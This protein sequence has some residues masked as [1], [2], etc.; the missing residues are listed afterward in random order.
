MVV[1]NAIS[2]G[3]TRPH[4]RDPSLWTGLPVAR[5][6]VAAASGTRSADC[7]DLLARGDRRPCLVPPGRD[8]D[9]LIPA[10]GQDQRRLLRS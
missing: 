5:F 2:L 4:S 7:P 3:E 1:G 6:R 10:L 9:N 8:P